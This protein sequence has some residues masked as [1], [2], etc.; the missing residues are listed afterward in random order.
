MG[1]AD[2]RA[3]FADA[4]PSDGKILQRAAEAGLVP[5]KTPRSRKENGGVPN[6]LQRRTLVS[7][8]AETGSLG[9]WHLTRSGPPSVPK[10]KLAMESVEGLRY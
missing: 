4:V 7:H 6:E 5:W 9:R 2:D 8:T 1:S 10:I 3:T